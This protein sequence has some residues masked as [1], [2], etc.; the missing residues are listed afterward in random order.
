MVS[1]EKPYGCDLC[2]MRYVVYSI[3]IVYGNVI[4][5]NIDQDNHSVGSLAFDYGFAIFKCQEA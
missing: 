2:S 1:G 4:R 3:N 5:G